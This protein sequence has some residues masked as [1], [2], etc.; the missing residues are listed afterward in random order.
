MENWGTLS[1]PP[2]LL[3]SS[4]GKVLSEE[5]EKKTK[6]AKTIKKF[7]LF[8]M[9]PDRFVSIIQSVEQEAKKLRV[10]KEALKDFHFLMFFFERRKT[11]KFILTNED[12]KFESL[13][14]AFNR[15]F[16]K[17]IFSNNFYHHP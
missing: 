12:A 9:S 16:I 4:L 17:G 7:L 6:I 14:L 2:K 10:V 11:L 3:F 1:D 8:P 15:K 13:W 5:E